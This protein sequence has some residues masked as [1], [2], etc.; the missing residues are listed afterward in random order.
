MDCYFYGYLQWYTPNNTGEYKNSSL[1]KS[2][3]YYQKLDISG[4]ESDGIDE[5]LGDFFVS[6]S[7]NGFSIS[8]PRYYIN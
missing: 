7:G 3:H 1:I 2:I 6:S 4:D 8:A 5:S